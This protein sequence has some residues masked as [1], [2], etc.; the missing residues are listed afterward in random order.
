ML[1]IAL[2][3]KGKL[4]K[5]I[6]ALAPSHKMEVTDTSSADI[7]IDATSPQSVIKNI[8]VAMELKKPIVVATTGWYDQLEHVQQMVKEKD[9]F[10]LYSPNFSPLVQNLLHLLP[11]LQLD[12]YS[13]RVEET[14]HIEKKDAPSGTALALAHALGGVPIASYR[15]GDVVG[16]HRILIENSYERLTLEHEGFDRALFAEGLLSVLHKIGSRKGM[17]NLKEFLC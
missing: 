13:V 9:G 16:K 17:Y 5:Q 1:K 11:K 7:L 12:G 4:A 8:N 14:H 10:C 2:F 6:L 3:G 15:I